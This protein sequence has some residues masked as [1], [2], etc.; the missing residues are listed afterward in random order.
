M[1]RDILIP[2]DRAN[3]P[4]CVQRC[5]TCGRDTN[6]QKPYCVKHVLNMPEAQRIMSERHLWDTPEPETP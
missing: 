4:G 5:K 1:L 2:G 3:P 6:Y